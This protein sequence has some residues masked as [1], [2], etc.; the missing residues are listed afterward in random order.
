MLLP[1][2]RFLRKTI[3]GVP[4]VAAPEEIDVTTAD[5]FHVVLLEAAGREHPVVVVDMSQTR[6]C[7]SSALHALLRANKRAVSEGS[8]L[9]LVVPADGAVPRI[10][11]LM[12]LDQFIPSFPSL[13]EALAHAPAAAADGS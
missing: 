5:E 6:F 3:G 11:R 10:M 7:D 8:E 1:D 2:V 13:D 9:H 12:C 4:V